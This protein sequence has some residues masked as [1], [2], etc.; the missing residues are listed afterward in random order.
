M[1]PSRVMMFALASALLVGCGDAT[2]TTTPPDSLVGGTA[3]APIRMI[4][5]PGSVPM[6]P[7][8]MLED[9]QPASPRVGQTY[10]LDAFTG[11]IIVVSLLEGF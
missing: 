2:K 9:I 8:W 4:D 6:L 10:G 11:K 7:L 5:A 3:D 1:K